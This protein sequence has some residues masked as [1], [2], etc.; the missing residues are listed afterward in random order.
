MNIQHVIFTILPAFVSHSKEAVRLNPVQCVGRLSG[1]LSLHL[2]EL[3]SALIV[4]KL[5]SK[6]EKLDFI[7]MSEL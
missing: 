6:L 4:V 5:N 2:V 1:E 3:K 7:V